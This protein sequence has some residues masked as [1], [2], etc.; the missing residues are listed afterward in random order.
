MP[1][2]HSEWAFRISG[3]DIMA[4]HPAGKCRVYVIARVEKSAGTNDASTAIVAG[5]YDN[6]TKEYPAQLKLSA[7]EATENYR[8]WPV[9]V[10]EPSASRDVFVAPASNPAV[11]AVWVDRVY[12]VP[13][14]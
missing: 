14:R 1:G 12:L 11:K 4:R 13:E 8:T 9:G 7:A 2:S 6:K 3:K 5:V 10:F